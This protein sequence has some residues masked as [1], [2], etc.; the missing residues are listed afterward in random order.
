M[1]GENL[2]VIREKL[3]SQTYNCWENL[4]PTPTSPPLEKGHI[5]GD[6]ESWGAMGACSLSGPCFYSLPPCLFSHRASCDT[7]SRHQAE[8]SHEQLGYVLQDHEGSVQS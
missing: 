6:A 7:L 1:A 3:V 5:L 4:S 2:D 8:Q